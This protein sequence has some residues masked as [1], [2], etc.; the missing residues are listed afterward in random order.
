VLQQEARVNRMETEIDEQA[1]RLL[2]L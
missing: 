1:V 2:A